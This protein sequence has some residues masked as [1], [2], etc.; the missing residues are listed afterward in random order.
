MTHLTR[1]ERGWVMVPAIAMLAVTLA[2]GFALLSIVDTQAQDAHRD[3]RADAAFNAAEGVLG[4][5]VA[6]LGTTWIDGAG[7][8]RA[9]TDTKPCGDSAQAWT[10]SA[11]GSFGATLASTVS[12]A[13]GSDAGSW[14]VNVCSASASDTA[15][16]DSWLTT[17][18]AHASTT[19][20]T[21]LWVRAKATVDGVTRAVA[22]QATA[23]TKSLGLPSNLAIATGAF[24][25]DVTTTTSTLS[26]G[27]VGSLVNK[28][29]STNAL[30]TDS[31]AQVGVRCALLN[32][33]SGQL[34]LTG[35]LAGVG[36]T[37]DTLGLHPL[38]GLLGTD[39][40]VNLD[41]WR[42]A[43][44]RQLD[45]YRREAQSTG[46]YTASVAANADCMTSSAPGKVVYIDQVGS[47][48]D[49]C[50]IR[51]TAVRTAKI[52]VVDK[53]RVIVQGPGTAATSPTFT[54]VLYAADNQA[55]NG[56]A[57]KDV[58]TLTAGGYVRGQILIDGPGTMK[59]SM[60][61]VSIGSTL[62]NS[63]GLLKITCLLIPVGQ[64]VD[65]LTST[66]GV[67]Q[68]ATLILPQLANYTA[69]QRDTSII[70]AAAATAYAGSAIT[71]GTFQQLVA[72]G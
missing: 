1:D 61:Q 34:C 28:L 29:L 30:I 54:G 62:C 49:A 63:L 33:L 56:S 43:S 6:V 64:L 22:A 60:P 15:W 25:S 53:G 14:S 2:L 46:V 45:A 55:A 27:V 16:S 10:S 24:A 50:Y 9:G 18:V 59:I 69:V 57:P 20:P 12:Q 38:N 40:N 19:S 48:D 26:S 65:W 67:D 51:Q 13:Y 11:T 44:Q 8:T 17:R 66:L 32:L 72:T 37:V 70:S 4:S 58:V 23:S 7:T 41:T 47:G 68:L 5:A 35:T 39:R 71:P 36:S 3:T 21:I 42:T 31:S 52:L